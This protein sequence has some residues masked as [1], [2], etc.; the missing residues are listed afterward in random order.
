VRIYETI[1]CWADGQNALNAAEPSRGAVLQ[2]VAQ[3]ALQRLWRQ[4]CLADLAVAYYTDEDWWPLI[5]QEFDLGPEDADVARNAA[6]WQ[7]FMQIRHPTRSRN[8]V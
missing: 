8:R 2:E 1:R 3:Q 7:R 5:A 6:Y 4:T